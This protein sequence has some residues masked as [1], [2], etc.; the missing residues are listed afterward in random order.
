[1]I[2]IEEH[3]LSGKEAHRILAV[4][5]GYLF[6]TLAMLLSSWASKK[7]VPPHMQIADASLI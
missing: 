2:A 3:S 7:T 5:E 6:P 4:H 1:M